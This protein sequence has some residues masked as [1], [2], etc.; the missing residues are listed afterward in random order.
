M[1]EEVQ[2]QAG[3]CHKEHNEHYVTGRTTMTT[4]Q[5]ILVAK[6]AESQVPPVNKHFNTTLKGYHGGRSK[7]KKKMESEVFIA[8]LLKVISYFVVPPDTTSRATVTH[9]FLLHHSLV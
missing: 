4:A 2:P 1:A 9:I 7:R 6:G 8:K 3:T 5:H